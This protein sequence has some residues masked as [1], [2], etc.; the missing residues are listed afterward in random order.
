MRALIVSMLLIS[1]LAQARGRGGIVHVRPAVT[2]TGVVRQP[3]LR[4]APD[5][6]RTNNWSTKGNV[7]PYTGK[8][9]SHK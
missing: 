5:R 4:T 7:N 9:G 1:S 6:T 8:K 3:H 2:R